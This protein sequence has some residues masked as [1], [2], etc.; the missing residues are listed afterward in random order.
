MKVLGTFVTPEDYTLVD[1]GFISIKNPASDPGTDLTLTTS[2]VTK[3]SVLSNT[4]QAGQAYRG[5][6]TAYGNTFYIRGYLTYKDS[7]NNI[8]TLYSDTVVR[9]SN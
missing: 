3:I 5:I 9:C 1:Q 6:K 7:S 4:N 2:G 8:I